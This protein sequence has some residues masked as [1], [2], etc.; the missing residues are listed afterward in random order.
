MLPR[1]YIDLE[2]TGDGT[3]RFHDIIEIYAEVWIKGLFVSSFYQ[4]YSH[5]NS[6][7]FMGGMNYKKAK[8][9]KEEGRG[10]STEGIAKFVEWLSKHPKLLFTS[11][12]A[13]FDLRHI[14]NW[15]KRNS[16][17]GDFFY[18]NP[19]DVMTLAA[20]RVGR[21]STLRECCRLLGVQVDK[22]KLHTAKYDVELMKSI[23]DRIET[24]IKS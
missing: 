6:T 5:S 15:L 2:T 14:Q 20:L 12:N 8:M 17:K 19:C 13:A 18:T 16:L 7:V 21:F 24:K 4:K 1:L 3:S 23:A 10:S 11:Y 9:Y 22:K